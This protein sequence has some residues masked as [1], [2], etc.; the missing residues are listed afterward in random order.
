MD[1]PGR[2]R[3]GITTGPAAAVFRDVTDAAVQAARRWRDPTAK[4]RRKKRRAR[5]RATWFG[6]ASGTWGVGTAT[7]AVASAPEWTLVATG[8]ATAV[9]AVP[10]IMAVRTV[11][12]L[13]AVPLPPAPPKRRPLPPAN[14]VARPPMERLAANQDSLARLL[15]V[16]ARSG[17]VAPDDISEIDE[18][19]RAASSAVE[20]V[21]E[22]VV[23]LESAARGSAAARSHLADA[24]ADAGTRLDGGVD[25]FEE[26]VA[27]AARLA[28]TAEGS[29]SLT[30]LERRRAELIATSDKL[31][32]WAQSWRE[33]AQIEQRYRR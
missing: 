22:D 11:R 25:Q 17:S 12:K 16:L 15:G 21:V 6:A 32:S 31:E 27:A 3:A 28:A 23:A 5:R 1:V 19:A 24:I 29:R 4:L 8:G 20:T 14:S 2:D 10:A 7:L 9:L 33:V 18:A 13:D 30:M 26:L